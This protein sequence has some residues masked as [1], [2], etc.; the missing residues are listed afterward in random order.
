MVYTGG[1]G[2]HF[3]WDDAGMVLVLGFPLLPMGIF[4]LV[5]ARRKSRRVARDV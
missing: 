5:Y 3:I 4:Y 1:V 2:R